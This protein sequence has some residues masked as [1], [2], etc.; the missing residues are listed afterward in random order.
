VES[1]TDVVS[2]QNLL[3]ST[4]GVA[5][6]ETDTATRN[7]LTSVESSIATKPNLEMFWNLES[8]GI[9]ESPSTC[10]DDLALDHFNNTV[11]FV[12][13]RYEV[14]WPWKEENPSLPTNYYLAVGR[15]KAILQKLQKHPQLLKQYEAIIQEQLQRGIIE[16]V[17]TETEEG[18]VKHYIPHHPV[19]T[20]SKST[21][22]VRVVYDASAKTK[23]DHKSLNEC[24]FRG[25]VMLP[26]LTGLLLRFRLSPIG[27]ISDIEKA[28]LNVGLQAKDRDAT[29]FLWL[30][31][32]KTN[33]I[34]DENLQIYR[35]CRIPF[36]IVSSPFLLSA[37]INYHLKRTESTTAEHLQ[38]EIYVDN[39]IT[40]V[41]NVAEGQ[42]L[43]SEAK[44]IFATASM[45]LREWAS[46]SEEL[47][48]LIPSHD[49]A[50]DS[51]IKVLGMCWKLRTDMLSIPGP[52]SGKLEG[53]STK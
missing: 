1:K 45:N 28:F 43:Y 36:G 49:K 47:M 21:T 23:Q 2:E 27:V 25:P 38:R 8:L 7:I 22:K 31:D 12:E 11:K 9:T 46:N 6:T 51:T 16:K 42:Q 17:G 20:P 53:V 19:I 35:F 37:T 24:L 52:S 34:S 30:N 4:M 10:D 15:L 26:D 5:P 48:A 32:T 13:G 44:Q 18:L 33:L 29:R 40:G 39:L 14:T 50:N 41:Q 3:V